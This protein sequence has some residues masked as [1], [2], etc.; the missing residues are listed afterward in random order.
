MINI[1]VLLMLIGSAI[2]NID[3]TRQALKI[4]WRMFIKILPSIIMVILIISLVTGFMT[5]D[6]IVAMIGSKGGW[7]GFL[8]IAVLGTVAHVPSLVAFP[9]AG[10]LLAEGA[11]IATAAVFITTLTM[12][13]VVTFPLEIETMGKKFAIIRNGFSFIIAIAIALIMGTVL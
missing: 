8:S 5:K 13:G 1:I 9:L 3:K 10:S 12:I 11:R 7:K 6:Q 2:V 4:S